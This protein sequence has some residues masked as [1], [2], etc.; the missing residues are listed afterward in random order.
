MPR[1][2]RPF[3]FIASLI[4]TVFLFVT[5]GTFIFI[6]LIYQEVAEAIGMF[7]VYF[8]FYGLAL[9]GLVPALLSFLGM[10][11]ATG[12]NRVYH[13]G[14]IGLV[15]AILWD[16]VLF[17]V[18]FLFMV[19]FGTLWRGA[20]TLGNILYWGKYLA[21]AIVLIISLLLESESESKQENREFVQKIDPT[22]IPEEVIEETM[23]IEPVVKIPPHQE[24]FDLLKHSL[25]NA[26]ECYLNKELT[27]EAYQEKKHLLLQAYDQAKK[28]AIEPSKKGS[29]AL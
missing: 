11:S 26:Q 1:K 3:V 23:A 5:F 17:V 27:L 24:A 7:P 14:K 10:W 15:C 29:L 12:T 16:I 20:W 2:M 28:P 25:E 8:I 6:A 19:L 22:A 4:N 21:V 18:G 13:I 9:L